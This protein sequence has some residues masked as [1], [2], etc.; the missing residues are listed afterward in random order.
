M[1]FLR[2]AV[3]ALAVVLGL[4]A[5]PAQAETNEV[6]FTRQRR[7]IMGGCYHSL[8]SEDRIL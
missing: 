8:P 1:P 5:A 6:R 4:A 2:R 3:G 7:E